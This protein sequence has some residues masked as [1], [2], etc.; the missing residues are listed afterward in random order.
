MLAFGQPAYQE[1]TWS[2]SVVSRT[3]CDQAPETSTSVPGASESTCRCGHQPD[4]HRHYRPGS[5]CGL[6]EC[7]WWS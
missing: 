4:A 1:R 6:C 7:P 5:D 3:P 2:G